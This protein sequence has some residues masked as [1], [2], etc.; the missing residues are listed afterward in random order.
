MGVVDGIEAAPG[1]E[2]EVLAVVGEDRLGIEEPAVGDVTDLAVRDSG[3]AQHAQ[4]QVARAARMLGRLGPGQ[5]R[6]V[7]C[8]GEPG[9]AAIGRGSDL[10]DLT[11]GDVDQAQP[12]VVG[13]DGHHAAVRRGGQLADAA[14]LAGREPAPRLAGTGSSGTSTD[15]QRIDA[16]GVGRPGNLAGGPEDLRI[17]GADS[18]RHRQGDGRSVPVSE[19]VHGAPDLDGAG[20]PGA[21][22]RQRAHVLRRGD[23]PGRP[24]G[25]RGAEH[26]LEPP[27][28]VGVEVVEQPELAAAGVDDALP[29]CARLACVPALVIGVPAQAG[30][31]E[32]ARVHVAGALVIRQERQPAAGDH[33]AGELARQ[34]S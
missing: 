31:V 28:A 26:D 13:G 6:R 5:P 14:E 34:V 23:Q 24:A 15:L 11:R 29:V 25:S 3:Q 1:Q 10:P 32:R 9:D 22:D 27:R 12:P 30:P 8:K 17:P 2:S 19:P 21:V 7:R 4:R 33:R 20:G 16:V 18:G